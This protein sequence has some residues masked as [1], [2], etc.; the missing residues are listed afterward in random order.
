MFELV[1]FLDYVVWV[2]EPD[3]FQPL[4]TVHF[5][6][7]YIITLNKLS[8]APDQ[9]LVTSRPCSCTRDKCKLEASLTQNFQTHNL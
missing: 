9:G 2:G 6:V 5:A 4:Q 3:Y 8:V 7:I 1:R